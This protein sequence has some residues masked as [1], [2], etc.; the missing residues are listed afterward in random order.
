MQSEFMRIVLFSFLILTVVGWVLSD[1]A[2]YVAELRILALVLTA[3]FL[4]IGGLIE[5]GMRR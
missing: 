1:S 2:P 3:G 5:R 4:Y